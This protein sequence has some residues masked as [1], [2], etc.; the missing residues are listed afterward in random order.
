MKFVII[1]CKALLALQKPT[2]TRAKPACM[3][4]TR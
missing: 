4:M 2:S 1:T 3:N